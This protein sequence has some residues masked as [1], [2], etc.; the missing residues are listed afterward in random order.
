VWPTR[1]AIFSMGTP[2]SDIS[3]TKLCRSSRGVQSAE[4]RPAA[5]RTPR[6][7][8]ALFVSQRACYNFLYGFKGAP[9]A[10]QAWRAEAV[11]SEDGREQLRGKE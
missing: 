7:R 3:E 6:L 2:A 8:P 4:F 10:R 1:R 11:N 9:S 5:A